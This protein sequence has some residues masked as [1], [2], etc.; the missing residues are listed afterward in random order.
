MPIYIYK[1]NK[2]DKLIETIQ[3][4]ESNPYKFHNEIENT[5]CN[6]NIERIIFPP[7]LVFK[8]TGFYE[9]DY[10]NKSENQ[11]DNKK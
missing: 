10:K 3:S 1:C 4:I 5:K 9:T 8:G 6:G 11:K 2:C 7:S